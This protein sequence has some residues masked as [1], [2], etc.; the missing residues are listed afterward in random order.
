MAKFR[1]IDEKHAILSKIFAR[2]P[3]PQDRILAFTDQQLE[4]GLS[5]LYLWEDL[6]NLIDE[7]KVRPLDS[8]GEAM[9]WNCIAE[10]MS[11]G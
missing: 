4:E 10:A 2:T 11:F 1:S 7:L 6:W 3:N 9:I 8:D 5:K